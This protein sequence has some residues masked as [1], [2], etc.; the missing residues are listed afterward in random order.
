MRK[1]VEGFDQRKGGGQRL[2]PVFCIVAKPQSRYAAATAD[3]SSA[4]AGGAELS[5]KCAH[6]TTPSVIAATSSD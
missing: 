4:L 5:L 6:K 3:E 1:V 2:Q